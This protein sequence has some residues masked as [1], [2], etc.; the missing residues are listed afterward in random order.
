MITGKTKLTGVI[1]HPIKHSFSPPMHN[2]AYKK[3]NMDY[4]Y[5]PF[6]ILPENI[7]N[8]IT[9]AKTMNIQGLNVTIPYKTTIIPQLDEIDEIAQKIGAVNTIQFKN[10]KAKGYN[11]D[12]IGAIKSLKKY[13]D[14]E[15]KN[16]LIL[17]AGGAS[18]AITFTLTYENPQNITIANRTQQNADTLIENIKKQTPYTNISYIPI[19]NTDEIIDDIDIIINTTPIGMTPNID[20]C[21]INTDKINQKHTVMDIIYNPLETKLLKKAK[22]QKAQTIPGTHMLVNQGIEAFKIFTNQTPKY[23]YFEKPLLKI[24]TQK[25]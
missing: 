5:V 13:T 11:T 16:I 19:Q 4:V 24:L 3:M 15:D 22:Q 2:T 12:G 25:Q 10:G 6:H 14:L 9:S 1:G 18:K 21:P 23:E 7:D 17:G 8:L 20:E